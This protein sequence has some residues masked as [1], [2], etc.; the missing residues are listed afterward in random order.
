M[1]VVGRTV[2]KVRPLT[3]A[4]MKA[5]G[6]E[7]YDYIQCLELD[8]GSVLVGT[9]FDDPGTPGEVYGMQGGGR[10][11]A[12]AYEPPLRPLIRRKP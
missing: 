12:I 7:D 9:P 4:E 5:A 8:D 1:P 10:P 6:W 2:V 3:R 11:Q